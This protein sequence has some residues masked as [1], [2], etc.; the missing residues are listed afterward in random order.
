[1]NAIVENYQHDQLRVYLFIYLI[2]PPPPKS[3]GNFV[4]VTWIRC[5]SG[6]PDSVAALWNAKQRQMEMMRH[7]IWDSI[8]KFPFAIVVIV[9]DAV[10][11]PNWAQAMDFNRERNLLC[12]TTEKVLRR[13][14][15]VARTIQWILQMR[16]RA[17]YSVPLSGTTNIDDG[18]KF[19]YAESISTIRSYCLRI[20]SIRCMPYLRAFTQS[21]QSSHHQFD[22]TKDRF[23][24]SHK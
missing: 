16:V 24:I 10:W 11:A 13:V 17:R 19:N 18:R 12:T 7:F 15:F 2:S 8:D 22:R 6:L 4:F 3:N 14:P 1:M 9:D 20:R 21:Q 5:S 23:I